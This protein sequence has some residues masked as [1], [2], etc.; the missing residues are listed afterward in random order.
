MTQRLALARDRRATDGA[1]PHHSTVAPLSGCRAS[2]RPQCTT[3]RK[4]IIPLR[5]N[6][7]D[8][9][10]VAA[11][12][13]E[14]EARPVGRTSVCRHRAVRTGRRAPRPPARANPARTLNRPCRTAR[15]GNRLPDLSAPGWGSAAWRLASRPPPGATDPAPARHSDELRPD[16]GESLDKAA[17]AVYPHWTIAIVRCSGQAPRYAIRSE[18]SARSERCG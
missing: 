10:K 16:A 15:P 13:E 18:R 14:A 1:A 3:R 7:Q 4:A 17:R 8:L 5:Q 2:T 6:G 11:V 12:A 9:C